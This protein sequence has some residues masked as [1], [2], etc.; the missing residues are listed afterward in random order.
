MPSFPS[1]FW[2]ELAEAHKQDLE[3]FGIDRFKR[4]QAF[5]YFNWNWRWSQI[6]SSE[7]LRFLLANTSPSGWLR[8]AL[9]P[10]PLSS[11]AW[12]GAPLGPADRWLYVFSV[13]LLWQYATAHDT[14]GVLRLPEPEIGAP[15]PVRWDGRLISQDLAN[16]ALEVS[17]I[18][19]ALGAREPTAFLE[20]GAGYG[21]TAYALLSLHP[22]ASYTIIDIEPAL[23]ISRHYLTRLFPTRQLRFVPAEEAGSLAPGSADVA[24][25]ISS[26]QEMVPA[27]IERYLRLFDRVAAGGV[28]YLKQWTE[29]RN[30]RDGVLARLADYPIPARWKPLFFERAPVQ[31]RFTQAAWSCVTDSAA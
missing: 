10:T 13:R 24:L 2:R 3:T 6:K 14:A 25:S 20:V 22:G 8:A 15:L 9:T 26:L 29:W 30:P 28:V 31:T 21:R 7:Q 17:A 27:E 19:R 16:T 18:Q 4:R 1:T 11:A 5:K 23:S 12:E